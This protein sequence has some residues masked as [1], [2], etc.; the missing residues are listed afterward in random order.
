MGKN[1]E[2]VEEAKE[3]TYQLDKKFGQNSKVQIFI[4]MRGQLDFLC[5][6]ETED[7][8]PSYTILQT[9]ESWGLEEHQEK[10][11]FEILKELGIKLPLDFFE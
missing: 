11:L 9:I 2:I 10:E 1:K 8:P 7:L 3:A 6:K 4:N 5:L